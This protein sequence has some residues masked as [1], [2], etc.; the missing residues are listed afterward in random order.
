MGFKEGFYL[1]IRELAKA[2]FPYL[3]NNSS[4]NC[5]PMAFCEPLGEIK[6]REQTNT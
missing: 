2:S 6:V 4:T 3:Q 5:K 1:R